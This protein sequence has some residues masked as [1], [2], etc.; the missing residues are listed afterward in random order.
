MSLFDRITALFKR[1]APTPSKD[2]TGL[3]QLG[4][5]SRAGAS[6]Y[7]EQFRAETD[8]ANSVK[9]C[10]AMYATDPRANGVIG[11]LARDAISGGFVVQCPTHPQ[12]EELAAALVERLALPTRLDD[13]VRLTLV[14]GDSFIE[15]AID[16]ALQ[17][18]NATRKPTLLTRRHS[19]SADQ[20]DNPARAFWYADETYITDPNTASV[21]WFAEWQ[22]IHARWAHNEGSRYG[23]PLFASAL[24]AWQRIQAGELD[25]AVRR[26]TRAGMKYLHVVEGANKD[27]LDEYKENNKDA[28]D[29]PFAAVADF[30]SSKPGTVTAIGGDASL[31]AI[32]DVLHHIRTWW[33]ASPVPM[34][35]LGY[36][37]DLNRDVLDKQKEQ[38]DE[39]L[40]Q[41]K[42][43]VGEELIKP[44]LYR[45]WLLHGIVPEGLPYQIAWKSKTRLT[46]EALMALA[47]AALSLRTLGLDNVALKAVLVKYLPDVEVG[48]LLAMSPSEQIAGGL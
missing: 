1:A 34:S 21:T 37:Q 36:G 19:N 4:R 8:R 33:L 27:E 20:F 38:Y 12:A 15:V 39:M 11:A 24:N 29:N 30:F 17:I 43:W 10:R 44:L 16:A 14:D 31:G 40:N 25:I 45:E 9:Q 23:T 46:P 7:L 18:V 22:I 47:N 2:L 5:S 41:V 48:E 42:H 32:D 6:A 26:K 13:W 3:S 28:L 35:L